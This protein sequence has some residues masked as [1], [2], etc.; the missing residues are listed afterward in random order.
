[1]NATILEHDDKVSLKS[2]IAIKG[3]FPTIYEGDEFSGEVIYCLDD[4][5]GDYLSLT[6]L[7]IALVPEN[8]KALAG[9]IS[10]RVRGLSE[11]KALEMIDVI[12]I[13]ILSEIKKDYTCLLK[14]SGIK[15]AK[16]KKIFNQ[17]VE[18]E[19]FENLAIFIQSMGLPVNL[20]VKIY[21][22][23]EAESISKIKSNPYII[24][25]N[26]DI[27]FIHADKIARLLN[28]PQTNT[29][30]ILI[31]IQQYIHHRV[32]SFGD[33]CV[34]K[35]MIISNLNN[36]LD[37]YGAYDKNEIQEQQIIDSI[38][39]L[40]SNGILKIELNNA[41]QTCVYHSLYHYIENAIVKNLTNIL[42]EF[43]NPFCKK[44]EITDFL[45]NY[46]MKYYPLDEK[47][48]EAVYNA[49]LNGISILTGGPGTG[50]TLTTNVIVQCI[51]AI[52]PD[53][54]I[55]LLAPTGKASD[56]MMELTNMKASTI[57]RELR[58]LPFKENSEL[59]EIIADFVLVDE[60]SMIDAF[61]FEKLTST[62]GEDTRICFVGDVD[63]LPSVGAGLILRD[64]IESTVIPTVRLTKIFRQ[65]EK[66]KITTNAH[67]IIQGLDTSN[68]NGIDISNAKDSDFLFWRLKSPMSIRKNLLVSIDKL[69]TQ[70]KYKLSDVCILTPMKEGDL[71]TIEL[72]RILQNKLN[73][74]SPN[75][76]E[77]EINP[78]SLFRVG[79]RVM[80]NKN[81]YDLEVFNGYVGTITSIYTTLNKNGV[82]EYAMTVNYPKL[83]YD[84][85]Y[86]EEDF[87]QLQ[88]SYAMTVHKSQGSEFPVVIMPI[89]VTQ[90]NMLNRNLFYTAVTRAKDK[91]ILMGQEE[92]INTAI[93][94]VS[95]FDRISRLKEKIQII[96]K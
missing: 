49:I 41:G 52:K 48:K 20:A 82:E 26:N 89:H 96:P 11:K 36:F 38:D 7:P 25:Y 37:R 64:M 54:K 35:E 58:I 67:K 15:D 90:N 18:H 71:G 74:P 14:V 4:V 92:A 22:K 23:F 50:K 45:K 51:K 31:A 2:N 47:Q 62:I 63:Q 95:I 93:N 19:T 6:S 53:A 72:N 43:K 21:N 70:Y 61:L 78:M 65:A 91:F 32:S 3:K 59:E 88:L 57:H 42:T 81:N 55:V 56:R 85:E 76:S 68:A 27:P 44:E 83:D 12:G 80:Q 16:A 46:E 9:F 1:M 66:S 87:E 24:C 77:Y 34:Y 79:D 30:R 33:I 10:K 13:D 73:P 94:E 28:I 60:S 86:F 29:D 69:F 40:C 17:L 39:R 5:Y 84:V 75:K 8:K